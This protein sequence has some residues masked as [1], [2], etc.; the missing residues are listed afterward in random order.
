MELSLE[1]TCKATTS[2]MTSDRSVVRPKVRETGLDWPA[3]AKGGR[4]V[5]GI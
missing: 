5:P 4:A 2:P 1:V 3:I